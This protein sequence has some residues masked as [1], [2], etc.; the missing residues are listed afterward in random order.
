MATGYNINWDDWL[1]FPGGW[2]YTARESETSSIK[3][4]TQTQKKRERKILSVGLPKNE[5][6]RYKSDLYIRQDQVKETLYFSRLISNSLKET[7]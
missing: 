3:Q 7:L 1:A 5:V 2:N 4:F 6:S